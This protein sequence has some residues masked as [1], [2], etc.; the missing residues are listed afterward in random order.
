MKR[1]R[2]GYYLAAIRDDEDAVAALGVSPART[3]LAAMMLSSF[4]AALGGTFY[5]QLVGFITPTRTIS[6]DFSVQMV[7]MAVLGGIGTV[8]G[9]L[10]GALVLVP[11]AELTRAFWGG[12]LQGVHLIVYGVLL[13]LVILYWPQGIDP[14]VRRGVGAVTRWCEG[15]R[16]APSP[17]VGVA[18]TA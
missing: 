12:S 7:I 10:W 8:L 9:P 6:L 14:W 3:K 18:S 11:V 17:A 1:S 4:F 2:L 13:V 16:A 15:W 5:A